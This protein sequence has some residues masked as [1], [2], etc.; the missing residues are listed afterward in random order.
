MELHSW[1]YS[2]HTI[3]VL[4]LKGPATHVEPKI[5]CATFNTSS[6]AY[7]ITAPAT[8]SQVPVYRTGMLTIIVS[9]LLHYKLG[10]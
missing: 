2:S 3:L 4:N 8:K 1:I 5:N 7:N 10:V 9:C 6:P